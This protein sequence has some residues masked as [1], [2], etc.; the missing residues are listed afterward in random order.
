V[1]IKKE[2]K[3]ILYLLAG[4][5]AIEL[6]LKNYS[7]SSS[8]SSGAASGD[9][10]ILTDLTSGITN[11]VGLALGTKQSSFV[12]QMQPI[13]AQIQAQYGIDPLITMTQAA[14]ESGW[15]TSG[16]TAK[17][18]NLYGYT[19][20]AALNSWLAARGLSA[21]TDMSAILAQDLSAAPFLL[22]QTH[23]SSP[24][25][26]QYFTHPGDIVSQT[27]NN[28]GSWDLMVWRP[29]RRYDSWLASVQDWAQLMQ[30][31]RY[32]AALADAKAG[33]LQ[34]FANDVQAAGYATETDYS[35]QLVSVGDEI[36]GSIGTA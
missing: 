30:E 29:F 6:Y 24:T 31:P 15:G 33:D 16:L 35:T 5:A 28:D 34:S 1:A 4:A 27:Q 10:G 26:A 22:M 20:D 25:H 36:S 23:E 7:S 19:G 13:A 11:A 3:T 17:A 32:A 21:S 12:S 9:G 18:N 8:A 2:W 14:L